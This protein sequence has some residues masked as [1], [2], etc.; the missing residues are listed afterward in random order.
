MAKKLYDKHNTA[1]TKPSLTE[2]AE[3]L[4]SGVK[5]YEERAFIIVDA[6][7]ECQ[8]KDGHRKRL[9]TE[10]FDIQA[11]GESKMNLLATSRPVP[12][13]VSWFEDVPS[14]EVRASKGDIERYLRGRMGELKS[15]VARRPELQEDIVSGLSDAVDGM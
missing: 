2:L 13:V 10:L 4:L 1:S 7:D 5:S 3:T 14:L 11:A 15:F 6:L 8:I 12:E 9:L